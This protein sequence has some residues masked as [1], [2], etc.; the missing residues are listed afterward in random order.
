MPVLKNA[1]NMQ[2]WVWNIAEYVQKRAELVL[3]LAAGIN[4]TL[5]GAV[6]TAPF[7]FKKLMMKKIFVVG[8]V[9]FFSPIAFAQSKNAGK[10]REAIK[11]YIL[12]KDTVPVF[13][14]SKNIEAVKLVLK[15]Y[16][17]AVEKLNVVG[18]ENFFTPDSQIFES[19]G[20]EGTYAYYLEHH[21]TPEFKEFTS[22]KYSDYKVNVQIDGKYAF[23]TETY[24]YTII[25]AKDKSEVK[26]KGV[27]TSV[28]KKINGEWKIMISHN[29]S[30]RG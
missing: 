26:R 10:D 24:G 5:E 11:Q 13:N 17:D 28:L 21:L 3:T 27:A 25:I 15:K 14:Q 20:S 12:N 2:L 22:F 30:R 6:N 29:S 18:T 9:F 23:A 7:H 4:N 1:I 19:G 8:Y 16:S